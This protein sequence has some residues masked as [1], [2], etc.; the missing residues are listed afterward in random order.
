MAI[1]NLFSFAASSGQANSTSGTLGPVF[2][3]ASMAA[4]F[5]GWCSSVFSPC[6][7]PAKIWIGIRMAAVKTPVRSAF[8]IDSE[9]SP[10]R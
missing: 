8:H 6:W 3:L 5:C 2:Q 10:V 1:S 4:I 9:R 7:S